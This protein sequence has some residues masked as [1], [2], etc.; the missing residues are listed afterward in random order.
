MSKSNRLLLLI[1][2]LALALLAALLLALP[3]FVSSAAHRATI[4]TL[5]SSLTG[6]QV[7]IGG[8]LSLALLPAPQLIAERITINSIV[9][10][11]AAETITARSLTLNIAV[12]ALLKGR[13]RASSMTLVS[14]TIT[15]P[16]PLP[17][18]AQPAWLAAL[19]A[20]ITN[21]RIALGALTFTHVNADI[22]TG[23]GGAV[24]FSGTFLSGQ[25]PLT[26]S[27]SLGPKDATGNAPV[28]VDAQ[29]HDLAIATHLSGTLNGAGE[30]TASAS[31][32]AKP[33]GARQPV[34][35]TANV[36]LTGSGIEA[37]DIEL[38][39]GKANLAGT[40]VLAFVS[41][42][43]GATLTGQ[44]I[45]LAPLQPLLG[46]GA[47][48][49]ARLDFTASNASIAGVTLSLLHLVAA[50]DPAG[51][52]VRQLAATLAGGA[53]VT[54]SGKF[55][56][57]GRI[58]GTGAFDAATAAGLNLFGGAT[59]AL[60][61]SW[62][63]AHLVANLQGDATHLALHQLHGSL[64][65]S[66][67]TGTLLF[68]AGAAAGQLNFDKL[69]LTT[70][71]PPQTA[72]PLKP[73]LSLDGEIAAD[74]VILGKLV[75]SHVLL[76]AAWNQQLTIRR[77]S[78]AVDGGI[79]SASANYA[80]GNMLSARALLTLPAAAPLVA[81]LP[82][83]FRLPAALAQAPLTVS[84][85]ARGPATA[86][87]SSA[88]ATLGGITVT[89]APA[90]NLAGLTAAGPLTLRHPD[91]IAALAAFGLKTGLAWP[92]AGSIGLTANFSASPGQFALPDFVLS[93]GD[94]TANGAISMTA[95]HE[96]TADIDAGTLALPPLAA[97]P[98][99]PWAA[100][101]SAAGRVKLSAQRVL[102]AGAPW[103]GP[104]SATL[105]LAPNLLTLAVP[106]ARL[107]DAS[108]AGGSFS[109]GL[110][111]AT[112]SDAPPRLAVKFTL[113]GAGAAGLHL[114]LAFPV[115]LPSGT[116]GA[117]ASLTATGYTPAVW[118]ATLAGPVTLSANNGTLNGFSLSGMTAALAL[119]HR[120]A[121]LRGALAGGATAY[122][123]LAVSG[124][125]QNG[126]FTIA[127]AGLTGPDGAASAAGSVDLADQ[128]LALNFS[129]APAV[130][131]PLTINMASIGAW[132]SPKLVP[133]LGDALNWRP[134]K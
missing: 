30:L 26:L 113:T 23:P 111:A 51:V 127:H 92:G 69:D 105:T 82:A 62:Q 84:L 18:G 47:M 9:P 36:K 52:V 34:T 20:Q 37:D 90:I 39:Q 40:A 122:A 8:K 53:A 44:N 132:K 133:A 66:R 118:Q 125:F 3:A 12:G 115:T 56:A 130:S 72:P 95:N 79:A 77:V 43:I 74:H 70:L 46:I 98:P 5:A 49:P 73:A 13:L 33:P 131:P 94:L 128:A 11:P 55:D 17:R 58:T 99:I 64:G 91:A 104:S 22:F 110:T 80:A 32:S 61:A 117:T 114:P 87:A 4:E 121:P 19:H 75:L 24:A 97:A 25:H 10:G 2:V 109:G 15:I 103:L 35:G 21:G 96:I 119:P 124:N 59:L 50:A 81:L 106:G 31:L 120:A 41:A 60:P 107:G 65:P 14:P 28:A 129:F 108:V 68:T 6:R 48:V 57:S 88:V 7:H 45:D 86:I 67:V 126:N 63:T 16:W 116:L 1:P 112:S 29:T 85:L 134:A 102:L 78:A 42:Q 38:R 76:D 93:L 101:G 100:L 71:P 54:A 123:K 27:V 83:A 89:A